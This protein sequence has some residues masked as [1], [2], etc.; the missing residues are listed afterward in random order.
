MYQTWKDEFV[1]G[2]DAFSRLFAFATSPVVRHCVHHVQ[3][4]AIIQYLFQAQSLNSL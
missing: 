1:E 2:I 4:V 3:N